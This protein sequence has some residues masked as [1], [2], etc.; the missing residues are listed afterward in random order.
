MPRS[1]FPG[2]RALRGAS[3]VE[4]LNRTVATSPLAEPGGVNSRIHHKEA[5]TN[6]LK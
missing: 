6:L 3:G 2:I 4:K 1:L 5:F